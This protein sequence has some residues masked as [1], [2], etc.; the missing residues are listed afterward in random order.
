MALSV[1]SSAKTSY[2]PRKCR[3]DAEREVCLVVDDGTN[4]LGLP[5]WRIPLNRR[6]F[7][8]SASI[9][10][11]SAIVSQRL[12]SLAQETS[13]NGRDI[14][15]STESQARA[16]PHAWEECVGS[17]RAIV[18]TRAQWLADLKLVKETT[19]IKSVRFHGLFN[20][21]MGVWPAGKQPNFLY[22]DTVFDS[23]LDC[24]V[25]P[26][27][28]LS[29]MPAKL[30]SGTKTIFWYHGNTTPPSAM[31]QWGELVGAL[32]K[33][34]IDRYGVNEVASWSFEVWNEPN[35]GFWAGTKAEYFELYRQSVM[36]LKGL[37][38]RLRVGGP[39]TA[40]AAWVADLLGYCADQQVPIDFASSHIYP[41]DPQKVVFGEGVKHSFEEVIPKALE[42]MQAEIAN[43]QLP[44][45]PLYITEWS[46]QNPAFIA[47][48]IK[49]TIGLADVLSYWTFD[50]VFE[51]LGIPRIFLNNNFGLLGQRGVPRPSYHTFSLLHKLG[52][53]EL[54]SNS[55]SVLATRRRDGSL[56][57]LLWNLIPRAPGQRS[58]MG[59]PF[60]QFG[61]QYGTSGVA[62]DARVSLQGNRRF[63]HAQITRVDDNHGNLQRAYQQI[64]SPQYPTRDQIEELKQRAALP[65]SEKI[66]VHE[67]KMSV[68]IPANGVALVELS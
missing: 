36:A 14:N 30:A 54:S 4:C 28:E 63:H 52:D 42:K 27:V 39:S 13:A 31:D 6:T 17:D 12:F 18:A 59:D 24:G 48:T 41:D 65:P 1:D 67:G 43:S 34:C 40:Q 56:A 11:A 58:S 32:G 51:E 61:D 57:I 25:R 47:H 46:S 35:I 26:F 38:K 15:I 23:M 33:H 20:D 55:D 64:G 44:H 19:G 37:D 8:R 53:V 68:S 50:N 3:N 5:S 21:E 7:L 9:V 10:G 60:T 66:A 49:S 62:L 45:T 2:A 29:F 22:V 16:L